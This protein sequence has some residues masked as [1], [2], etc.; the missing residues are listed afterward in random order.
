MRASER[1]E[2]VS[3]R[4]SEQVSERT[5]MRTYVCASRCVSHLRTRPIPRPPCSLTF[6][7]WFWEN[8]ALFS[9]NHPLKVSE[10]GRPPISHV[11]T[12]VRTFAYSC[13]RACVFLARAP[14]SPA[15][16]HA[17]SHARSLAHPHARTHADLLTRALA[18]SRARLARASTRAG[19]RTLHRALF[20]PFKS[21]ES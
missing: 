11:R 9:Q 20:G 15:R 6:K 16:S 18:R 12:L 14:R 19:I 4:V 2:R 10:Q 1:S 3:V 5:C 13:L 8:K 7:G 17:R 21:Q